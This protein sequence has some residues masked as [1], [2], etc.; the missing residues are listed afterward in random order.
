MS[1]H[2]AADRDLCVGAGN[3]VLT[4][5]D[6]F[7]QDEEGLVAVLDTD[8]AAA[9]DRVAQAVDLCPAGAITATGGKTP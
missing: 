4:A 2:V 1:V 3:C 8:P 6:V 9:A 5:P 7:D